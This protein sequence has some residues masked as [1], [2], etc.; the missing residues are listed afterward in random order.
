M[1][2]ILMPSQKLP[3]ASQALP[4]VSMTRLG[5]MALKLSWRWTRGQAFIDPIEVGAGRVERLVGGRA[6][7]E[8]F[9]PKRE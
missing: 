6:M 3:K 1:R 8:V 5:S 7:P 2:R 4:P 9:F